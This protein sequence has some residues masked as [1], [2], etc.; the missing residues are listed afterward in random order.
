MPLVLRIERYCVFFWANE[1]EPLEPVHVHVSEGNPVPH[2]TKIWLLASG[3]CRLRSNGSRIEVT[4]PNSLR[5]ITKQG[6][7]RDIDWQ[8]AS[9][10][11]SWTPEMKAQAAGY[12]RK[13]R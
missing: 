10:A 13:G 2:A 8:A 9:R 1:G 3:H 12:A 4:G 5:F 11:D 6:D 7:A